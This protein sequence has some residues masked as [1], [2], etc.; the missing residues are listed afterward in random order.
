[1]ELDGIF[2]GMTISASGLSAE[3]KRLDLIAKNI[4][5]AETVTAPGANPYRR[6]EPIFETILGQEGGIDGMVKVSDVAEDTTTPLRQIHDPSHPLA[7][8]ATGL[9][10]YSNVNMAFEMVDMVTAS[11]T[12]EANMKAIATYRDMINQSL[13][14]LE[15]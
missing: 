4:A 5:N 13:R 10:T 6:Q 12:Y 9:V 8:K 15:A 7:D 2:T 1:M 3:R 14:I 11:R